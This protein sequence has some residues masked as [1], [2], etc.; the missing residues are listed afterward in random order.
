MNFKLSLS[1]LENMSV[2]S[3]HA[4]KTIRF[5]TFSFK[6]I[7]SLVDV[8]RHT[9]KSQSLSTLLILRITRDAVTLI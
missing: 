1:L 7:Y 2:Y 4:Y 8:A 9:I 5:V 6:V 3:G